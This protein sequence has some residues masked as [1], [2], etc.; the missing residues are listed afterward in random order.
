MKMFR[1][2]HDEIR[3]NG[4]DKYAICVYTDAGIT[5]FPTFEQAL[6]CFP[7]LDPF[8]NTKDFTWAMYDGDMTLR[9]ESWAVNEAL[10]R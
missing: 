7:T 1:T 5:S 2:I 3:E 8:K 10:S 9:F 4:I 6:K